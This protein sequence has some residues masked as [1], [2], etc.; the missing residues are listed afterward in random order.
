MS[1]L[2]L[3]LILLLGLYKCEDFEGAKV[4]EVVLDEDKETTVVDVKA[5]KGKD[6][7]LKF[8]GNPTT[9]YTWVLLNPEEANG[10][11]LGSNFDLDG[12]G[13]YVSNRND[14]KLSG[15]GGNF[16]YTFKALK[17]SNEVKE[18][19][20]SYRRVWEKEQK[21]TPDV[22]VRITVS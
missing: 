2:F 7:A 11:I 8:K 20:F 18:L 15:V 3:C 10:S 5:S 13:E 21:E 17:V 19:N 16:Y 6:F 9:G 14:Q 22:V 1:K 4:Y 12:I